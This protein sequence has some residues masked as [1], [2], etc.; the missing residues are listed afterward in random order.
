MG[1]EWPGR[2]VTSGC[3]CSLWLGEE[4]FQGQQL[5]RVDVEFLVCL[6]GGGHDAFHALDCE[7]LQ[8]DGHLALICNFAVLFGSK[9]AVQFIS[10]LSVDVGTPHRCIDAPKDF[11]YLADSRL[12]FQE[13]LG[14]E[15]GDL[16]AIDKEALRT[17]TTFYASD[18]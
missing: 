4:A 18:Q 9:V 1:L 17:R 16:Q 10:M 5:G 14:I 15:V 7:E 8:T 12:V 11:I 13:D 3:W 6:E 2:V